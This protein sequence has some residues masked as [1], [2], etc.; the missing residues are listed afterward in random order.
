MAPRQRGAF[1]DHE[2]GSKMYFIKEV[3]KEA[4]DTKALHEAICRETAMTRLYTGPYRP[5]RLVMS[6][7]TR[8]ELI[9]ACETLVINSSTGKKETY[10]GCTI[11]INESLSFG[12]ILFTMELMR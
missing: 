12:D 6:C 7:A 2:G 4:L 3:K 10:E 8:A 11:D 5:I 9:R 1:S